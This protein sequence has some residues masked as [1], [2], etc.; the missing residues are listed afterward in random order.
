MAKKKGGGGIPELCGQV[1]STQKQRSVYP[2]LTCSKPQP[3][4]VLGTEVPNS[5]EKRCHQVSS[6]VVSSPR[7]DAARAHLGGLN[8]VLRGPPRESWFKWGLGHKSGST[9]F[10]FATSPWCRHDYLHLM[11]QALRT[12]E[13]SHTH[14]LISGQRSGSNQ[15]TVCDFLLLLHMD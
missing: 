14:T 15:H 10:I 3:G 13:R 4:R 12:E 7:Q 5:M 8:R 2:P 11:R 9:L 1:L 6:N